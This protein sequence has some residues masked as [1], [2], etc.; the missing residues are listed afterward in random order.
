MDSRRGHRDWRCCTQSLHRMRRIFRLQSEELHWTH[1]LLSRHTTM[2]LAKRT[3][4]STLSSC[5]AVSLSALSSSF[6]DL[7]LSTVAVRGLCNILVRRPMSSDDC[8]KGLLRIN[9]SSLLAGV[10][11]Q[12]RWPMSHRGSSSP[13][14]HICCYT[15]PNILACTLAS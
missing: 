10:A 9:P 13:S 4:L 11:T 1:I 6:S 15:T 12:V 7:K 5:L 8:P 2:T 3:L 14:L